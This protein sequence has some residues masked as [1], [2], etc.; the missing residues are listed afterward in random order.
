MGKTGRPN[1]QF[2]SV[3]GSKSKSLRS[4]DWCLE[5]SRARM[6]TRNPSSHFSRH[7]TLPT[8]SLAVAILRSQVQRKSGARAQ[9]A[10]EYLSSQFTI[11]AKVISLLCLP[12]VAL[13]FLDAEIS[14]LF[15][16]VIVSLLIVGFFASSWTLSIVYI[17]SDRLVAKRLGQELRLRPVDVADVNYFGV[18]GILKLS[19]RGGIQ[20][21][22]S[23]FFLARRKL[24]FFDEG[25]TFDDIP[26]F[27]RIG[28]FCGWKR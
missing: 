14:S 16:K 17:E 20:G 9:M 5:S 24:G 23:V 2:L 13:I 1:L 18:T 22:R 3:L 12:F 21:N 19:T 15:E 10:R 7:L 28:R 4:P 6:T 25:T 8:L 11:P 26:T 27:E